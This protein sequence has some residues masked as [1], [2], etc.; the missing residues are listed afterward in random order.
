MKRRKFLQNA[1]MLSISPLMLPSIPVNAIPS[2]HSPKINTRKLWLNYLEKLAYPVLSALSNDQL[3]EKMP[4]ET[5]T[6]LQAKDRA[7]YSH[8]EA[9]GRLLS[10]IAPWLQPDEFR[11]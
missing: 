1:G 4:V 5:A 9:F 2:D 7:K 6:P 8:L 10:G 3:K 11:K